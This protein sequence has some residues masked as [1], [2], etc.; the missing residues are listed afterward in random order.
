LLSLLAPLHVRSHIRFEA[1]VAERRVALI[2]R[3]QFAI[4]RG[5]PLGYSRNRC[6]SR[7]DS[8]DLLGHALQFCTRS[9][10]SLA[11]SLRLRQSLLLG[12]RS[13]WSLSAFASLQGGPD[14][15]RLRLRNY[16]VGMF[17]RKPSR[18]K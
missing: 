5:E 6:E 16:D 17:A 13:G 14:L 9:L 15:R 4:E 12:K 7:L 3:D 2:Q 18:T 10:R 11:R 1:F 8:P